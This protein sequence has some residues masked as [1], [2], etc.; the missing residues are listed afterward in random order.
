MPGDSLGPSQQSAVRARV[1]ALVKAEGSQTA[2]AKRLGISQAHVSAIVSG[3]RGA[4]MDI[5]VRL[6]KAGEQSTGEVLG[7]EV[8]DVGDAALKAALADRPWPGWVRKAALS[9]R[10]LQGALTAKRWI[11][12]L[13]G[14]VMAD[15]ITTVGVVQSAQEA[16]Y[17]RRRTKARK[18]DRR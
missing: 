11:A 4:G 1:V 18:T 5:V 2:A 8:E 15:A 7:L 12:W 16:E 13:E 14:Q 10:N 3:K 9:R 6:A 17:E